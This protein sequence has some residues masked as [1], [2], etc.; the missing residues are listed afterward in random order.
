MLLLPVEAQISESVDASLKAV[1]TAV[2]SGRL[3]K[4]LILMTLAL[5]T[6][7]KFIPL[8]SSSSVQFTNASG[9]ILQSPATP[10]TPS[11]LLIVAAIIPA[12]AVPC[13]ISVGPGGSTGEPFPNI[14]SKF[15]PGLAN[16][17]SG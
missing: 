11:E 16:L 5:N 6:L 9:S 14:V 8:I 1:S 13:P 10:A 7:A 15:T 3:K 4:I 17:R 2:V 12:T